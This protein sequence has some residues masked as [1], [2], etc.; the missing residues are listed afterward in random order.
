MARH[1]NKTLLHCKKYKC[2]IW[3]I[4]QRHVRLD[5]ISLI[6]FH[7]PSHR[8]GT[9]AVTNHPTRKIIIVIN[10]LTA[11]LKKF[12]TKGDE[13]CVANQLV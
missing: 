6:A 1:D 7:K 13:S 10:I 11:L 2:L 5:S 12:K 4:I 9:E 8:V 3:L